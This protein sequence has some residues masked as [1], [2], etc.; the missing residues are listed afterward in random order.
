MKAIDFKYQAEAK[1]TALGLYSCGTALLAA[2]Y[3]L[4]AIQLSGT[5]I[6]DPRDPQRFGNLASLLMDFADDI[7]KRAERINRSNGA[8]YPWEEKP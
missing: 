8:H 5:R 2:A 3:Q 7:Q 6:L 1:G 4:Q